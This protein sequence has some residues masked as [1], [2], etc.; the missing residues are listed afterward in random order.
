MVTA[1]QAVR[2]SPGFAGRRP[3]LVSTFVYWH[4]LLPEYLERTK[5]LA[6][7]GD[8]PAIDRRLKSQL[9]YMALMFNDLTAELD[10]DLT[11]ERKLS[12][13][14]VRQSQ[15]TSAATLLLCGLLG[16]C[17]SVVL[18]VRVTLGIALPL[19]RMKK[20]AKSLAAGHFS[21]RIKVKGHNELATLSRAFNSASL[22]LEDLYRELESRVAQRTSQLEAAKR[23]AEAGNFAKSQF[24]ANMSHEIRTPLNG[25]IGMALLTLDTA[26]TDEQRESLDLLH[27]SAESLKSL[28]NDIL[29]L[30]K[31][32]AGKLQLDLTPF[33]IRENLQ[34][35]LQGIATPAYEKGLDIICDV[36]PEV[37]KIITADHCLR[38]II[39]NLVGNAVKFTSAVMLLSTSRWMR[40]LR[41][42]FILPSPTPV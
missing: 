24:L 18:S 31:V 28:L 27:H 37:P 35:W 20:A 21:H 15:R 12:L 41:T 19:S 4:Y 17:I 7:L 29:D 9:S 6:A 25:I 1:N 40:P 3:S 8:W 32:D 2:N 38:Q 36:A 14:A 23:S 5:R 42:P 22:R 26:L 33:E 11:H 30:S 13:L 39:V 10:V 34:E 16:V